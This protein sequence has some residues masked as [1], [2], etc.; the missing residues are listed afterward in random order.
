MDVERPAVDDGRRRERAGAPTIVGLSRCPFCHDAIGLE[1]T[2]WVACQR[3]LARHHDGCWDEAAGCA[4]CGATR[5][6]AKQGLPSRRR[7]LAVPGALLL[8]A[9]IGLAAGAF[10]GLRARTV[11]PAD[12]PAQRV[13]QAPEPAPQVYVPDHVWERLAFLVNE[14]RYDDAERWIEEQLRGQPEVATELRE[15]LRRGVE[16]AAEDFIQTRQ[17]WEQ[18][19]HSRERIDPE[20]V[21]AEIA[22]S[23]WKYGR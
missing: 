18:R 9:L 20:Q 13:A 15:Q 11:A 7:S 6:L 19:S 5:A 21:R 17:R 10:A 22:R 3:C 8:G 12:A 23:R 14:G 2:E 4:A 1:T 16:V